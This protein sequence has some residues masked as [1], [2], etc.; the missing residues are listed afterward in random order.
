MKY[1]EINK[2]IIKIS[3]NPFVLHFVR[4]KEVQFER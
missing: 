4:S 1:F 3:E 2:E